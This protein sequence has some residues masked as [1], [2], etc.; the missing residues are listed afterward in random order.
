MGRVTR[1]S[2]GRAEGPG[3]SSSPQQPP[4]TCAAPPSPVGAGRP[5]GGRRGLGAAAPRPGR[6]RRRPRARAWRRRPEGAAGSRAR[7]RTP[8]G[9]GGGPE[10]A[11]GR[12]QAEAPGGPSGRR[13]WPPGSSAGLRKWE[14][15]R[16]RGLGAGSGAVAIAREEEQARRREGRPGKHVRAAAEPAA[17]LLPKPGRERTGRARW[18]RGAGGRPRAGPVRPAGRS[19]PE[20]TGL[21]A[22]DLKNGGPATARHGDAQPARHSVWEPEALDGR[23]PGRLGSCP[24]VLLF[25]INYKGAMS[26]P[27]LPR[28]SQS[29]H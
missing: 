21:R 16:G 4:P 8:G 27:V 10:P 13:A 19:C 1:G 24:A 11:L 28:S 7:G 25:K 3:P 6:G 15:R 23:L 9:G 5:P 18:G 26:Q 29:T 14:W 2:A 22:P 12:T 17:S 20:E